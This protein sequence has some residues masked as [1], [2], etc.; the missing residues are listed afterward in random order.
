MSPA[1]V[2][3]HRSGPAHVSIR[4]DLRSEAAVGYAQHKEFYESR[5]PCF[6]RLRL[7]YDDALTVC[8]G[9]LVQF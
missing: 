1:S 9:T 6:H 3:P 2:A 7:V 5:T 4:W 8:L